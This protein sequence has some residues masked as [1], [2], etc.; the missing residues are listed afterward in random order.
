M[1]ISDRI[2]VMK[3]GKVLQVGSPKELYMTPNSI[4]VAHFIGES[5]FLEGHILEPLDERAVIELRGSIQVQ[6][7][8]R[9]T[10]KDERVVLAIR[11]EAIQME[12]SSTH[13]KRRAN[14]LEGTVE[15]I[16]FQGDNVRY[17][18]RL[19][20]LDPLIVV[21]PSLADSWF[22]AGEKVTLT[23]EPEKAHVFPYP[24][25]GLKEET[26]VE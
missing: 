19:E 3:K 20:N 10:K 24:V 12:K 9:N 13:A 15:K 14:S 4:F 21:Q 17:D 5:N 22:D 26:T 11:P 25:T 8:T 2:A 16:T 23:F 1:S 7:V 18:V 6:A